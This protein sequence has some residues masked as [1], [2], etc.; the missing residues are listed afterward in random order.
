MVSKR[1]LKDF[2]NISWNFKV[3]ISK[4]VVEFSGISTDFLEIQE[5]F[6]NF[7]VFQE[8]SKNLNEFH[9]ILRYFEV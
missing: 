7:K 2:K 6:K 1:F 8:V 5:I 9:R 4:F 3:H